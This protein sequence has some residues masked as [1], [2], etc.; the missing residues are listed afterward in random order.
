MNLS[1]WKVVSAVLL[2]LCG[3]GVLLQTGCTSRA[4]AGEE[5]VVRMWTFPMLPELRDYELY[6]ELVRDF[7][8]ENPGIRVEVEMLPWA[9]RMQK[10]ITAIWGNRAPDA[11]Y[12]N[13]D[14]L[15]R[16]AGSDYL[17]PVGNYLSEQE[18]T[19]YDPVVLQAVED[20]GEIWAFPML[21][22]VAAGLYNK[23]LFAKA[24]LDPE[25]PPRN[26]AEL[27]E[28]VRKITRDT[29]GDGQIDQ[30]GL[31]YV[32]GGDTLN[33]TFW[34]LLWQAGGEVL[35]PDGR[36]A[37][38]NSPEGREAARFIV[39]LFREGHVPQSFLGMGGNEF[40]AGKI[41]YWLGAGQL[42]ARQLER[43]AP[44]LNFAVAPVLEHRE[45][46]SYATIGTFA[47]FKT[48]RHPKE[49]ALWLKFLTRPDNM[50][51]FCLATGYVPTKTS[52]GTVHADSP[53]TAELERQA[54]YCRPDVKSVFARQIMQ[55]LGPELQAA[56]LGRKSPEQALDDAAAAVNE[57][58]EKEAR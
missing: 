17:L 7:R 37:A 8:K 58:L 55:R 12:L 40:A 14:F 54:P 27:R 51:K 22:T 32:L 42:E 38:F 36:K 49:A 35:T 2:G 26:W 15:P 43:D 44:E 10:M 57:M 25:R 29:N 9:G 18:R 47:L 5:V 3:A 23:D 53:R 24:G 41:G 52:L 46:V 20:R 21:R 56:A 33:Y 34:P 13:L 4:G 31:A 50:K 45:R 19:D 11:V 16:F 1:R 6:Q 39:E 28:A 30:W 48:S